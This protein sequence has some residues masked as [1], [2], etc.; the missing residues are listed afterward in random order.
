MLSVFACLFPYQDCYH[1]STEEIPKGNQKLKIEEGQTT[2]WPREKEQKIIYKTSRRTIK[3]GAT[4]TPLNI[5]VN[6]IIVSNKPN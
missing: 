2:Q 3:D 5:G 6:S 4:R 1:P